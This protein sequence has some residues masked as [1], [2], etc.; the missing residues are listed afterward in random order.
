ML[1]ISH[2]SK[3]TKGSAIYRIVDYQEITAAARCIWVTASEDGT[4]RKLFLRSKV[5]IGKPVLGFAY[6]VVTTDVK[7][8]SG[9]SVEIPRVEWH[10]TVDKTAED[11]VGDKRKPGW[12]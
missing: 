9:R 7:L 8:N 4:D 10:E 5:N 3:H 12:K 11:I 2:F 6:S 1:G